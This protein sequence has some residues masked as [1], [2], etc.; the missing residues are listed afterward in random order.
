MTLLTSLLLPMSFFCWKLNLFAIWRFTF[1][2]WKEGRDGL[3]CFLLFA[4]PRLSGDRKGRTLIIVVRYLGSLMLGVG[5]KKC[6][7]S[8]VLGLWSI[9]LLFCFELLL[10]EWLWQWTEEGMRIEC[11]KEW[12]SHHLEFSK[13]AQA[14]LCL[15]DRSWRVAKES[16]KQ[17]CSRNFIICSYWLQTRD[18]ASIFETSLFLGR[19]GCG[20]WWE[21]RDQSAI[22]MLEGITWLLIKCNLFFS[23]LLIRSCCSVVLWGTE[24][25]CPA[26]WILAEKE[27]PCCISLKAFML[28]Q[29]FLSHGFSSTREADQNRCRWG[30]SWILRDGGPNYQ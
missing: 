3:H 30:W 18:R 20:L 23:I 26:L 15:F 5:D 17:F 8:L 21:C 22:F 9:D 29:C 16:R 7:S 19:Y 10:A 13:T 11:M 1:S 28:I 25:Y 14:L 24:Q 6:C 2:D 27:F 12:I 4:D